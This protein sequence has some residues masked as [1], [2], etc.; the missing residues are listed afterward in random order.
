MIE[1]LDSSDVN[2]PSTR[3]ETLGFLSLAAV[4]SISE[5]SRSPMPDK[6]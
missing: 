2:D 6:K 3:N 4:D 5:E 1:F